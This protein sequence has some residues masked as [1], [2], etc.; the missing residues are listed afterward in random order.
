MLFNTSQFFLFLAVVLVLFYT[1]GVTDTLN[2]EGED[3]GEGRL[4]SLLAAHHA[5][6]AA[7]IA[8]L[9]DTALEEFASNSG[10]YDDVTLVLLKRDAV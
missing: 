9:I 1:D 7:T 5:G 2:A 3:F 8:E 6:P 4:S 10:Q